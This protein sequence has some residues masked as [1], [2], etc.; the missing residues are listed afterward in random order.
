MRTRTG[1]LI[2]LIA[3]VASAQSED[4]LLP[5]EQAFAFSSKLVGSEFIASWDIADDYYMYQDKFVAASQ[6]EGVQI[7]EFVLP[8]GKT[9]EDP[10][11]GEVVT[12]TERVE[13]RIPLVAV[14][15][16]TGIKLE[17]WGQGCNEPIGVCYPPLMSEVSM[18][19]ALIPAAQASQTTET[20][21]F[22]VEDTQNMNQLAVIEP[23]STDK[24]LSSLDRL[25]SNIPSVTED[26]LLEV[27]DAFILN[28]WVIDGERLKASFDVAEGYYLYR[29]KLKFEAM[30]DAR[31][32]QPV[33]PDS[34]LMNDAYFGETFI[35]PKNF[36]VDIPLVRSGPGKGKLQ[37]TA[38]Y[39][40]CAKDLI[41]YPPVKKTFDVVLTNLI[42]SANAAQPSPAKATETPSGKAGSSIWWL[43]LTAFGTGLLLTF[44]PCV[45]PLIPILSSII[46]GNES[47]SGRIRGGSLAIIYVLGTV[48]AYAIVGAVAGATGDQLQAYFQ[49]AWAIGIMSAVFALM[50]LSLFGLYEIRMPSVFESKVQQS[51]MKIGGGKIS[52]VFV[53]GILSALVVSA[54]VSPLLISVL[55]LAVAKA[56]PYLG[57]AMMTSMALGMGAVLIAIGFG[58]GVVLPKAGL[59]MDRLKQGFGVMLLGVAI[60]LL[61][62]IPEVPVLLLW[63]ALFIVTGVFLGATGELPVDATGWKIFWKGIGLVLL[64]WGVLSLI[65]GVLGNRDVFQPLP[66][67]AFESQPVAVPLIYP[68]ENL[69]EAFSN[70]KTVAG[71]SS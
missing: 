53:L 28:V 10:L 55:G 65:G 47:S 45:L 69:D 54:C 40:G 57:A 35:Y 58:I 13:I 34:E 48:V 7:G 8:L 66:Q 11:F 63:A 62:N 59:W 5:P 50:A 44:T 24:S 30:G 51:T 38:E 15:P 17:V 3:S 19:F 49:N 2:F 39:Q 27:D 43:V 61:G 67:V 29:D 70:R 41:C 68:G 26:N 36:D 6:T 16:V 56:D 64:L 4:D 33:L 12:Y 46:A 71:L 25:F 18:P 52:A 14:S 32:L 22:G 9:K 42:D 60:Y 1:L 31:L 20:A 21:S 37:L 23:A